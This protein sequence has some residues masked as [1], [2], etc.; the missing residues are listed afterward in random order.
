MLFPMKRRRVKT[1]LKLAVV[2]SEVVGLVP[3]AAL[4]AAADY[5][6]E[7]E[8]LFLV[9]E[10]QRVT[11][12]VQRLG[13]ASVAPFD[14]D[15]RVIEYAV[16]AQRR[17]AGCVDEPLASK[18]VRAFVEVLGARTAAPGGGSASALAAAMG[19]GRVAL[20]QTRA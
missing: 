17:K 14:V 15:A 2:G 5:Y 10:R 8:G 16:A 18:T 13:L 9:D 11:L 1:E 19:S 4:L 12:A 7:R 6:A 3:L 20:A